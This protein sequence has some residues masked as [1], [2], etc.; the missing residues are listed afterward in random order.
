VIKDENNPNLEEYDGKSGEKVA[1]VV[2]KNSVVV[3]VLNLE[4]CNIATISSDV[5]VDDTVTLRH[6]YSFC[7]E[8]P[9]KR[10]F[11]GSDDMNFETK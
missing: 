3:G 2:G 4:P 11:H 7:R 5:E 10:R 9:T 8:K 1:D 6:S